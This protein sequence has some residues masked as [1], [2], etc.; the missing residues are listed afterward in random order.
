MS[1]LI[2]LFSLQMSM[3]HI[4]GKKLYTSQ[5]RQ[6]FM[7]NPPILNDEVGMV[8]FWFFQIHVV[9]QEKWSNKYIIKLLN[10]HQWQC[11]VFS[12]Y[13]KLFHEIKWNSVFITNYMLRTIFVFISWI[14]PLFYT[15][16]GD[17]LKWML[18]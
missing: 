6:K 13:L 15:I 9:I 3:S 16:F 14:V 2:C 8:S 1:L 10:R 17:F 4:Q 5:S 7:K 11:G 12:L 18:K